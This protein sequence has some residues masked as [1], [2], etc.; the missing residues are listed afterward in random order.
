M[1]TRDK[2]IIAITA[3]GLS[4]ELF[5]YW[6]L[7]RRYN[8]FNRFR[9]SDVK[10]EQTR[11]M[12]DAV[13]AKNPDF[14]ERAQLFEHTSHIK[15]KN[16]L[17]DC[18]RNH[19]ELRLANKLQIACTQL[20]WRYHPFAFEITMKLIRQI[21]N[22][23]MRYHL[24]FTREWHKTTDGWYSVWTYE[25]PGT[26]PIVFFPGFGFGAIPYA[27]YA[28]QFE[29]TVYM[30]EVPNIGYATPIS[31]RHA[32]SETIYQVVSIYGNANDIFA[33]SLGGVHAAMWINETTVRE[34]RGIVPKS[35]CQPPASEYNVVICD[36]FV[37]PVDMLRNHMYPFVDFCDYPNI[38]KKPKTRL[39][40]NIFL[41]IAAHNLEFNSWSKRYHNWYDGTMW[42]DY[43]NVNIKYIYS[44]NDILYDTRYIA[45]KCLDTLCIG[46]GGHGSVIFGKK[47]DYVFAIIKQ[48]LS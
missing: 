12:I 27:K 8:H 4:A 48:W 45:E 24:G 6:K 30:I 26:K 10:P 13:L 7:S 38:K 22:A 33:H 20:Y 31:D 32:T 40:F 25:V 5:H 15:N 39:E 16:D 23:Y 21:G 3:I 34:Q 28:K 17:Y 42:R 1:K 29:R 2:I 36:G 9:C 41:W 19:P 37:N 18:L 14:F 11:E 46:N 43:P 44:E 35:Q 47:R